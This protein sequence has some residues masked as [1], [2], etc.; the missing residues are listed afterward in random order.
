MT[1]GR[2]S[3]ILRKGGIAENDGVFQPEHRAFWLYPTHLH[4]P[5]Q[6]LREE[7]FSS[8]APDSRKP[9]IVPISALAVVDRVHH[10]E[11][12]TILSQLEPMHV[13]TEETVRKRFMYR[14][15]GLWVLGVRVWAGESP[16]ELEE[17]PEYAG[18]RSWVPL[19]EDLATEDLTA[20]LDAE[21]HDEAMERLAEALERPAQRSRKGVDRGGG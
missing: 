20:V 18:C 2:Q 19:G 9:G 6:G 16:I 4:E 12:E 14:S 13:W 10:V 15:P 5:V 17:K 21:R 1:E 11:D 7:R 8:G 3:L